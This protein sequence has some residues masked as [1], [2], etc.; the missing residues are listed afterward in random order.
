MFYFYHI[1]NF[2][3]V[4]KSFE[5]PFNMYFIDILPGHFVLFTTCLYCLGI[6]GLARNT[7][8]L[9]FSLVS[10]EL[11]LLSISLNFIYFSIT[12]HDPKGQIF[13]LLLLGI[14]ASEAAVGLSLLIVSSQTKNRMHTT[15]FNT[16][17]G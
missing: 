14:A 16:L 10:M 1:I 8:N 7:K 2:F 12:H 11:I 5:K 13:A 17:K 9:L 4:A 3:L 15:D 6:Y